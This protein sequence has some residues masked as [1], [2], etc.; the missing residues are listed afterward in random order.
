MN[1]TQQCTAKAVLFLRYKSLY[2]NSVNQ[3]ERPQNATSDLDLYSLPTCKSHLW[4]A[5][6]VWVKLLSLSFL[7]LK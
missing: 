5:R 3:D 6:Y 1:T 4:D 7:S 2:A